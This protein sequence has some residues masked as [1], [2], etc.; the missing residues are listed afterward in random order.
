MSYLQDAVDDEDEERVEE[1]GQAVV[2]DELGEEVGERVEDLRTQPGEEDEQGK[3][4]DVDDGAEDH[5]SDFLP[6]AQQGRLVVQLHRV[7]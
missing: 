2:D 6:G 7:R 3:D 1:G 5:H 4:D